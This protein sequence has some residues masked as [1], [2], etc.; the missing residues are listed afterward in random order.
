[1][2]KEFIRES[3]IE[4]D[5]QHYSDVFYKLLFAALFPTPG[6]HSLIN[7]LNA[8]GYRQAVVTGNYL[9][10]A[11]KILAITNLRSG[12]ERIVA[13]EHFRKPK[14]APDSYQFAL[15]SMGV[16]PENA[17]A[18]EDSTTGL[19]AAREAGLRVIAF[20]HNYNTDHDFTKAIA[21]VES[22]ADPSIHEII[23]SAF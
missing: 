19:T 3:G 13:K 5:E 12:F 10:Q 15:R 2:R 21:M 18:I 23:N 1:M 14:P 4:T 11:E 9:E 17:I 20:R 22:F 8:K 16:E 7:L 6:I